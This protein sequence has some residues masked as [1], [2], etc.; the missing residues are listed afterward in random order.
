M[1]PSMHSPV[2]IPTPSTVPSLTLVASALRPFAQ[3]PAILV[4]VILVLSLH[5]GVHAT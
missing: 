4:L 3:S 1:R 5:I 2:R